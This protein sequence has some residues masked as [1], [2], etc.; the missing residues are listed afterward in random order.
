MSDPVEITYVTSS[1]FKRA[2]NQVF[3]EECSLSDGTPVSD[4]FVFAMVNNTIKETLE[5]RLEEI[6]RAEVKG[7]YALLRRPCIVEHAGLVFDDYAKDGYPGGLTK[8]M[9]NTLN[10]ERFLT[11]THSGGRGASAVAVI[12]YCDGKTVQVFNGTTHGVLSDEPRGES[13]FYWDAIFVPDGQGGESLTY[14]EIVQR[15]GVSR[16]MVEFSQS[17]K[18]MIDFLEWRLR[19][20]PGLWAGSD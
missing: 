18:A 19:N 14:A 5:V 17:S 3:Y 6:V 13:E 4:R 11:E 2:E 20:Q 9:W 1:P 8:P 7:A 12:G 15:D 10:R 16:K